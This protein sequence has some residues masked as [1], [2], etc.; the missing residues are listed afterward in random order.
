M[1]REFYFGFNIRQ[2]Q[3]DRCNCFILLSLFNTKNNH[4]SRIIS[5]SHHMIIID[6][7]AIIAEAQYNN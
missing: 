5:V 4:N 3:C 1:T 6:Y 2:E 7:E